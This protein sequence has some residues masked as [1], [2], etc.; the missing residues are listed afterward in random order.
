MLSFPRII[1]TDIDTLQDQEEQCEN[2]HMERI[3]DEQ[4]E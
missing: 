1:E 3:P 4:N 2:G